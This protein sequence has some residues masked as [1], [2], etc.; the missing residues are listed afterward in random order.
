MQI[1][2]AP[3]RETNPVA[4]HAAG[5]PLADLAADLERLNGEIL[6]LYKAELPPAVIHQ[7]TRGAREQAAIANLILDDCMMR[8]KRG[9]LNDKHIANARKWIAGARRWIEDRKVNY[10]SNVRRKF[11]VIKQR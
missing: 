9:S 6:A 11:Y 1:L 8:A 2:Q 10:A 7:I 4:A 3:K 5:E